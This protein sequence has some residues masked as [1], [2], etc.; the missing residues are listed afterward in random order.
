V[1]QQA[2]HNFGLIDRKYST[3]A[4]YNADGLK[5]Q[6]QRFARW[7]TYLNS[8]CQKSDNVRYKVLVMGR[9]GQG[10]H[11]AAESYY[12]TPAWNVGFSAKRAQ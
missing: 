6:W 5:T 7:V 9:H 3:D 1:N 12:G 11:N 8:N 4:K 2:E 10:D